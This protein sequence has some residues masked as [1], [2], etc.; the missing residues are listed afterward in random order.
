MYRG[1]THNILRR[2]GFMAF[3][4]P[5]EPP[6]SA[7][8]DTVASPWSSDVILS[9]WFHIIVEGL[10]AELDIYIV[11]LCRLKFTYFCLPRIR[12]AQQST[13]FC[14][15]DGGPPI[16]VPAGTRSVSRCF[17]PAPRL[18]IPARTP[19][20]PMVMHRRTDLWGPDALE[21]DPDRFLD[22]RLHKY[23]TFQL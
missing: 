14:S 2:Y 13:I 20:S 1:S 17:G 9:Y 18:T 10:H 12:T 19:F 8:E 21:F 6:W 15:S 16:Y 22:E 23:R 4:Y 5:R 7:S 11:A 3:G